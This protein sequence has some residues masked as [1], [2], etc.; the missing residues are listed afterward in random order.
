[1]TLSGHTSVN[2][3]HLEYIV[4]TELMSTDALAFTVPLNNSGEAKREVFM[5]LRKSIAVLA[6]LAMMF[7][8]AVI[9][10]ANKKEVHITE[11]VLIGNVTLQPGYYTIEW[12]GTAPD[13]QV[14]FSQRKNTLVTVPATLA[15]A[16]NRADGAVTYQ[17]EVSGARSLLRIETKSVTLQFAPREAGGG[18]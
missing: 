10:A 3:H 1:M 6:A 7:S 18:N 13:V 15:P 14:S 9:A 5:K 2:V 11:T 4:R 17:T 8:V 16:R 12:N